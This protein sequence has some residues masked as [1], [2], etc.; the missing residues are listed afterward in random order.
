MRRRGAGG[1]RRASLMRGGEILLCFLGR[2]G[3][4]EVRCSRARPRECMSGAGGRAQK[5]L[6]SR[7]EAVSSNGRA[8]P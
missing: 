7:G 6:P 3:G 8:V 4:G 2:K 5:V 1:G